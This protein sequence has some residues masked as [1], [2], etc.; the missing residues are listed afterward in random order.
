MLRDAKDKI[1]QFEVHE[2]IPSFRYIGMNVTIALRDKIT[3]KDIEELVSKCRNLAQAQWNSTTPFVTDT[4]VDLKKY[5]PIATARISKYDCA[6]KNRQHFH[7]RRMENNQETFVKAG[8]YL[9]W[10]RHREQPFE[11]WHKMVIVLVFCSAIFSVPSVIGTFIVMLASNLLLTLM[12]IQHIAGLVQSRNWSSFVKKLWLKNSKFSSMMRWKDYTL[13][14]VL[15]VCWWLIS[16]CSNEAWREQ[17]STFKMRNQNR[18]SRMNFS[19]TEVYDEFMEKNRHNRIGLVKRIMIIQT[20]LTAP[21]QNHWQNCLAGIWNY[22]Q[23]WMTYPGISIQGL[24]NGSI[25]SFLFKKYTSESWNY[26]AMG[27]YNTLLAA[28]IFRASDKGER[29]SWTPLRRKVHNSMKV[30]FYAWYEKLDIMFGLFIWLM[31]FWRI[32]AAQVIRENWNYRRAVDNFE[33]R[34][35][36]ECEYDRNHGIWT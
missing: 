36:S 24:S 10:A 4:E 11:V 35:F 32:P 2:H 17:M 29:S 12:G 28:T 34:N 31:C 8:R 1:S 3:H 19:L 21:A 18:V 16:R 14:V 20:P 23:W 22:A 13:S 15:F 30:S 7:R 6:F 27:F 9:G 26:K 25:S 5:C 33:A